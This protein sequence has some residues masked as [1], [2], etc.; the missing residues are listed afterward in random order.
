MKNNVYRKMLVRSFSSLILIKKNLLKVD[1]DNYFLFSRVYSCLAL[2]S[3][4]YIFYESNLHTDKIKENS[5][6]YN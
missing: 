4:I 3:T 6:F 5:Y 2:R 1:K